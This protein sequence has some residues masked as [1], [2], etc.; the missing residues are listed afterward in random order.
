MRPLSEAISSDI[1]AC[2]VMLAQDSQ[3]SCRLRAVRR[4][5]RELWLD[6]SGRSLVAAAGAI[7]IDRRMDG[8]LGADPETP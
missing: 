5:D 4:T 8:K 3:L 6:S 1:A 2:G 7:A